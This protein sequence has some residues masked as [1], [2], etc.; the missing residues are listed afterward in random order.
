MKSAELRGIQ[1]S[2]R[3]EN[4]A[5]RRAILE[6]L[7]EVN[8]DDPFRP[9]LSSEIAPRCPHPESRIISNIRYLEANGYLTATWNMSGTC[10]MKIANAGID[11]L[12]SDAGIDGVFPSLSPPADRF[13]IEQYLPVF[14]TIDE[15]IGRTAAE[16]IALKNHVSTVAHAFSGSPSEA[17]PLIEAWEE[18]RRADEK[19]FS[20]LARLLKIRV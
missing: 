3:A 20:R 13:D 12:E 11:L 10:V 18:I 19:V 16:R 5:I 15:T 1:A 6:T 4:N 14:E 7:Y 9:M 2:K 8:A 17:G